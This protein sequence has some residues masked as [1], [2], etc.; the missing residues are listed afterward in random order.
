MK[1]RTRVLSLLAIAAL[2]VAACGGP[3]P[4]PSAAPTATTSSLASAP[5]LEVSPMQTPSPTAAG[6]TSNPVSLV[7]LDSLDSYQ[8]VWSS[9]PGPNDAPGAVTVSGIAVNKPVKAV[10]VTVLSATQNFQVIVVGSQAWTTSNGT[11]WTA[12]DPS[13]AS[14]RRAMAYANQVTADGGNPVIQRFVANPTGFVASGPT[15]AGSAVECT[16]YKDGTSD[17]ELWVAMDG[18]YP[19]SGI[20]VFSGN[21]VDTFNV[22][23][24]QYGFAFDIYRVNDPEN[25]VS[26]PSDVVATPT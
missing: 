3:T 2:A 4:T 20:Y 18:G 14:V 24:A 17:A 19:V 23:H 5:T 22:S 16:L 9:H 13:A 1:T 6:Q 26:P 10:M 21:Y 15:L 7:S 12:S 11:T 25:E 8:F